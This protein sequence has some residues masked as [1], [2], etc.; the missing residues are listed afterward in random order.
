MSVDISEKQYNLSRE[1]AC[2]LLKVSI[3][4]VDRYVK[5]KRLSTMIVDGR[6]WLSREDVEGFL[7]SKGAGQVIDNNR[8]STADM[9]SSQPVD[10]MDTV[11]VF[12]QGSVHKLSTQRRTVRDSSDTFKN[13]YEELKEEVREKQERLEIANYRVG[14]LESQVRNSIPMLEYHREHFERQKLE[15]ELRSKLDESS[16]LIKKLSTKLKYAKL[17]KRLYIAVLLVILALQPL[18]LLLLSSSE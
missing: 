17:G 8:V 14:Q 1:A 13:L 15:E 16:G 7:M 6:I 18:W 9:S 4:T 11:E 2:R 12:N 5:A 10:D 3:R